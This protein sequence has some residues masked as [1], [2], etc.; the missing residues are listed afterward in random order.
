MCP[1]GTQP[2]K[3]L[4]GWLACGQAVV[5]VGAWLFGVE[6]TAAVEAQTFKPAIFEVDGWYC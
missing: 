2:L 3:L 5:S 6:V 1:P 4:R